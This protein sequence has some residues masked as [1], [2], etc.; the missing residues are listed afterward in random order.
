MKMKTISSAAA[1][2]LAMT[3]LAGC[4]GS[5]GNAEKTD[6]THAPA[7]S[8]AASEST[9]PAS[10]PAEEEKLVGMTSLEMVRAMGNG[11]NLGN[12][13]EVYNHQ[14]YTGGANP[15]G[16][17]TG[18][19]QPYT[20]AEMIQGMKNA[21][22]DTI[23]IPVAWT[24][25]M[26]FEKDD[27]TIDERLMNRVE[28]VVNYALEADMYVIINDHWDGGWWGMF[29]SEDQATRDKAL[30][31]Y[32]SMWTQIG[33]NFKDYSHKL[34][35]ESANEELGD[36]LNDKDI[37]G[38]EGVLKKSECYETA[39]MINSEFVKL[40]RSQ[41]GNNED[42]FLLIAGYNTDIALTCDER[43]KMPED[44]ADSKLL[45]SVHY[46][47]PWD[48][49]G[50]ESVDHW[51]SPTDYD[52]QNELFEKLSKFSGQGYGVVI[53]EYAV[54]KKNG[55]IKP[56]TDKFYS[57]LMDNCDLYDFC[58]V[59]WDCSNFYK[60]VSNTTADETLAKIF[61]DRRY[62][63]EK[64]KDTEAVKTEAKAR[65]DETRQKAEDEQIESID[66]PPSD[67]MAIAWI[68]YAASDYG[69]SYSVGD[70]YDP[71]NCTTGVK[72]ENV[73]ITGEGTYTVSLDFSECGM[74]KGVAFSALG[75]SNGEE[76]FPGYTYT[77]D[78]ILINGEAFEMA[79][80]GYTCSDDGK[81][82]R[83]NLY[84]GWVKSVPEEARTADGDLTDCSAQIMP[85]TESK[86]IKTI[87]VTFTVKA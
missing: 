86:R 56:D 39:N 72:A 65:I 48:Y 77:I 19:G 52:E 34:I 28:T 16:F 29:G 73:Q 81:C 41:G 58:P 60:R 55:G 22:F 49:C 20:T 46:Y 37:T 7:E 43:F 64:D 5:G 47:T 78:E 18:W 27:Y 79:G 71:T 17:E 82:T 23:R 3:M 15:D 87:S 14:S 80:K 11:I 26:N 4:A 13:L 62:E 50:T 68:M 57:N 32:K 36:R 40:I 8:E 45:L 6:N 31:M 76:L 74:A 67:D 9:P 85:L 33:E 1:L 75:I 30:E 2:F 66:L 70:V 63:N 84:N 44:T 12:T 10:D 53:G 59:L 69:V 38:S 24:N 35:F 42:R 51:G 25:G 61:S 54:M 21:G 83:V